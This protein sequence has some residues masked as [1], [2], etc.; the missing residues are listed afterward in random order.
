[1]EREAIMQIWERHD[2]HKLAGTDNVTLETVSSLTDIIQDGKA[3][4]ETCHQ[5]Q[6]ERL[7]TKLQALA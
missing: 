4:G 7:L 6:H 1:M 3:C 5:D 2:Y